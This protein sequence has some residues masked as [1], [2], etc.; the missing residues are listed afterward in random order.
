MS[1]VAHDIHIG[2]AITGFL[3]AILTLRNFE[4]HPWEKDMQKFCAA[5][6]IVLF[7]VVVLINLTTPSNYFNAAWNFQYENTYTAHRNK[8]ILETC[9]QDESWKRFCAIYNITRTSDGN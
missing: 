4:K 5:I 2:G 7:A 8:L 6:L 1:Q 9:E 3:V